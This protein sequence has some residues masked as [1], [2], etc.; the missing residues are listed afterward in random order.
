MFGGF[1]SCYTCRFRIEIPKIVNDS[2]R[3]GD[4]YVPT[5][6]AVAWADFGRPQTPE[7]P[8]ILMS[9]TVSHPHRQPELEANCRLQYARTR[10]PSFS[11]AE[12]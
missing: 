7:I 6:L 5:W 1:A 8:D 12:R 3:T 9:Y 10:A 2:I 4:E 11:E